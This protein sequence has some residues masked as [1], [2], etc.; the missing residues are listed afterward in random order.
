[1]RA[2]GR[3]KLCN[4][5]LH[6][7]AGLAAR[8]RRGRRHLPPPGVVAT[9]IGQRGGLVELGWRVV[10]PFMISPEKGAE[11]PGISRYGPGSQAFPRRLCD[12]QSRSRS[13]TRRR[14][15]AVSRAVYGTRAPGWS[16]YEQ[17]A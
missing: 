14:W 9:A 10:K 11:T 8:P 16:A 17:I 7:G 4:I 15:T 6:P 2:Y 13:P 12:P 1:M 3:S 5:L